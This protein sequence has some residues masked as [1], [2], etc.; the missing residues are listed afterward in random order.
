MHYSHTYLLKTHLYLLYNSFKNLYISNH[1]KILN[2]IRA[3]Y[4]MHIV[5]NYWKQSVYNSY[6][7]DNKWSD[8]TKVALYLILSSYHRTGGRRGRGKGS[9][10]LSW[11]L[12]PMCGGCIITCLLLRK[13]IKFPLIVS[14][15]HENLFISAKENMHEEWC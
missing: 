13:G 5:N 7:Y 1:L 8:F 9:Y 14:F 3:V 15:K 11:R 4:W 10:S 2:K 12:L 6:N